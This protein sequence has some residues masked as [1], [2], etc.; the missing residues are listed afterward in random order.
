MQDSQID[1]VYT[2]LPPKQKTITTT[3]K[4]Q[5]W[6]LEYKQEHDSYFGIIDNILKSDDSIIIVQKIVLNLIKCLLK[7]LQIQCHTTYNLFSKDSTS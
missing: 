6:A 2:P 1:P 5:L 3:T 4:F 7:Y